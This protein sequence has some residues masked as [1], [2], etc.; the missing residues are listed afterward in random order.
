MMYK[1]LALVLTTALLVGSSV[2]QAQASAKDDAQQLVKDAVA[3]LQKVQSDTNFA[4]LIRQAKGILIIPHLVKGAL[5][6]GGQ[7]GQGVLLAQQNG[8]W[9][10]PAFMDVGSISIGPQAGGE[11][12]PIVMLL[13][14]DKAFNQF[15]SSNN[16]SL[17]ASAG[18]TLVNYVNSAPEG[19]AKGDI[20][21]WSGTQGA[22]AG[23]SLIGSDYK[24]D[25]AEDSAYY[26]KDVSTKQIIQGAA[27]NPDANELVSKLAA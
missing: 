8:A 24:A 6:V 21:V 13:M 25:D 27:H 9:S 3:A 15:L 22:Y 5:V 19:Q 4:G 1:A 14:S 16:F 20:V 11:A 2:G 26:G 7:S 18:L 23:A 17:G 12:G 10:D